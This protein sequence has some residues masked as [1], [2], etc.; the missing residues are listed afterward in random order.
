MQRSAL[1]LKRSR[2]PDGHRGH[3]LQ[4][5]LCG[6]LGPS[7]QLI[8]RCRGA[9]QEPTTS[10]NNALCIVRRISAASSLHIVDYWAQVSSGVIAWASE[11]VTSN[12]PVLQR[13]SC[14]CRSEQL[15]FGSQ[16]FGCRSIRLPL[17]PSPPPLPRLPAGRSA[18]PS[19]ACANTVST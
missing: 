17:R 12:Q 19:G 13:A 4:V 7:L 14:T 16:S 8:W 15:R 3:R 1:H 9:V 5:A 2:P 6:C 18:P 10:H 11:T